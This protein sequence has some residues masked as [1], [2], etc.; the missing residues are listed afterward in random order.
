MEIPVYKVV[1]QLSVF[2]AFGV[3]KISDLML[4]DKLPPQLLS[5]KIE[6]LENGNTEILKTLTINQ[7]EFKIG[8]VVEDSAK[9]NLQVVS[10][11]NGGTYICVEEV[12]GSVK[13]YHENDLNK[14]AELEIDD[15]GDYFENLEFQVQKDLEVEEK[16]EESEHSKM[17][18]FFFK[19]HNN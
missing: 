1:G 6:N 13:Y 16:A 17:C 8:E 7:L 10:V 19:R 4:D 12:S 15:F 9:H 11:N 14:I 2:Y 5:Q 3:E 18:D